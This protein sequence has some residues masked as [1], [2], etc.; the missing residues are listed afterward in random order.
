MVDLGREP[1][2]AQLKTMLLM[3][4]ADGNGT[5]DFPEFCSMYGTQLESDADNERDNLKECFKVFDL[6]G[7]GF[8]DKEEL[9]KVMAGLGT[10]SFRAPDPSFIEELIKDADSN[11]DGKIDFDEVPTRTDPEL[12]LALL[13][14][15]R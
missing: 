8:L 15:R 14:P 9:A 3:A 10:K 4:D 6:D 5:I 12:G 7:N 11:G 1:S 13:P 2:D